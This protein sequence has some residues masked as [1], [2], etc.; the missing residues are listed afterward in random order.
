MIDRERERTANVAPRK[1]DREKILRG[2]ERSFEKKEKQLP[3]SIAV[4]ITRLKQSERFEE[5]MFER[6]QAIE[7]R[8]R[9]TRPQRAAEK[10]N[11][12][13]KLLLET[14]DPQVQAVCEVR[15][16]WLLNVA[17]VIDDR[18]KL[19]DLRATLDSKGPELKAFLDDRLVQIREESLR[20]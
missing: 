3:H 13:I 14:N 10:L 4:Y 19:E 6:E 20:V 9:L 12:T 8:R 7:K 16:I 15:A 11:D 2:L 1:I 17:G 5:A 18:Q